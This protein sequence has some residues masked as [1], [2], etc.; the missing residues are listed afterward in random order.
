M[1]RLE[2]QITAEEAGMTAGELMR[3]VMHLS[4]YQI[5]RN[6]HL[7]EGFLLDGRRITVAEV[8]QPG[9]VLSVQISDGDNT[10]LPEPVEGPLHILYED[11]DLLVWNKAPGEVVHPC[12]GHLRDTIGNR[13]A[14]YYASKGEQAG[15]HP[16]QRLDKGTSGIL[17]IAKHSYV[18]QQ[19]SEHMHTDAFQ[20]TYRAVCS[21]HIEAE[22]GY[23][24]GPIGDDE[25]VEMKRKV[26]PDGKPARTEY[27]VLSRGYDMDKRP[28]T[29]VEVTPKTGR[30][31]QIRVHFSHE[32]H[33]LL[34]D[35]FYGAEATEAFQ[36]AALHAYRLQ[37]THPITGEAMTFTAPLPDD[38][39]QFL[40]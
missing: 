23:M 36:R 9:Q 28:F 5:R 8:L 4:T 16:V 22:A 14:A 33:P 38:M 32:G 27:R 24:D 25:T 26:T 20:R 6:K 12:P 18:Q 30:T 19:L 17:L 40:K 11:E 21:G 31:H 34:G 7:P 39:E 3:Q 35:V 13:I 2:H 1:R 37:I 29:Y 10:D 15:F